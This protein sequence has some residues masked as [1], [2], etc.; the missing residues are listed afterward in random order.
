M[1]EHNYRIEK[2]NNINDEIWDKFVLEE[3]M[4][5]TFLQTRKFL[6]YHPKDRF[7]DQSYMVFDKKD[8]LIAV[9]PACDNSAEGKKSFV[10]HMGS[11]Y[12]GIIFKATDYCV[13]NV[14]D[15][16]QELEK[17]IKQEGYKQIVFKLTPDIFSKESNNLLQFCLQYL[18]YDVY[19]D[20]SFYIDF[21]N[22]QDDIIKNFNQNKRRNVKKCIKSNLKFKKLLSYEE[23]KEFHGVLSENL[24]KYDAKPV[25]TIDEIW[26]FTQERFP[27]N[28]ECFGVYNEDNRMISGSMTFAFDG[29]STVHTQYLCA[30]EEYNNLSPMT[31]LYYKILEEMKNRGFEKVSWGRATEEFGTYINDGLVRQK[32]SFG[33]KYSLNYTYKKII[34]G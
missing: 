16:L 24:K 11:T 3:S 30:L 4:N 25:H 33:S 12:G 7:I 31:F 9:C 27:N 2:F 1:N 5:G 15:V 18:E 29:V 13:Q 17:R 23:I 22:Y 28:C 10:S 8:R 6:N 21:K 20:L 32:E 34:K 19:N 14:L 26:E